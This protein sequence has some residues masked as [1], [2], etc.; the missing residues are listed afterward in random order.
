MGLIYAI[1]SVIVGVFLLALF[2]PLI[3][4]YWRKH[5]DRIKKYFSLMGKMAAGAAA[6][7]QDAV[8]RM[9]IFRWKRV[10][11]GHS[12][13]TSFMIQSAFND[14]FAR[15]SIPLRNVGGVRR[16]HVRLLYGSYINRLSRRIGG[17]YE[18]MTPEEIAARAAVPALH[19]KIVHSELAEH[20]RQARYSSQQQDL[21]ADEAKYVNELIRRANRSY[22]L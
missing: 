5:H 2:W 22:R 16:A 9:P 8:K 20:Y 14:G 4:R 7:V 13:K 18:T 11:G 12:D 21:S 10:R 6:N 19:D 17:I 15:P 3:R 1:Y